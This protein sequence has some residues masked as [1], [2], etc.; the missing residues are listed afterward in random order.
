MDLT[1]IILILG[2]VYAYKKMKKSEA[3]QQP[4]VRFPKASDYGTVVHLED[5]RYIPEISY[6]SELGPIPLKNIDLS[7]AEG[8]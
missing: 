1:T 5:G 2:G 8:L 3:E 4:F 6:V 7:S